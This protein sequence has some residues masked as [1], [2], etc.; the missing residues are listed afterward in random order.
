MQVKHLMTQN[1]ARCTPD[2]GLREVARMMVEHDCGAI[3][4]VQD[5]VSGRPVGVVTDRDIVC[6]AVAE[7]R[8]PL[9]LTAADVLSPEC[10]TVTPATSVEDCCQVLEE[11]QLRRVVVVD[12]GGGCCGVVSQ[13]DIARHSSKAKLAEVVRHV[14]RPTPPAAAGAENGQGQ[15]VVGDAAPKRA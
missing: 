13:A 12:D 4:V 10:R 2:T 7:G 5:H 6:R 11:N 14:S 9:E 15:G 8:N 3:P 1:P